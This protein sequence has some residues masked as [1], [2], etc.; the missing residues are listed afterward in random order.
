MVSSGMLRRVA[1]GRASRRNN[2]E[3]PFFVKEKVSEKFKQ[4][5]LFQLTL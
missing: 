3:T 2:P 4:L 1:F 5:F